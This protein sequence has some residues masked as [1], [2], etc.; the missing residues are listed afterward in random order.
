MKKSNARRKQET[1]MT[2][3]DRLSSWENE[4]STAFSHLSRPQLRGLVLWSAGIALT[5]AAGLCQM[6]ALLAEVLGQREP[7]VFQRLREWYL[8]GDQKSGKK[9]QEVEVSACF[10]P[11]LRWVVRLWAGAENRLPLVMDAT[12]LGKRST[13][14]AVSV[15]LKGGAIPVAWKVLC[16]EEEGSWR[17]H[18]EKLFADLQGAIPAEWLVIVLADRGLYARWL[19]DAM[20]ACGWH[21]F[22]RINLGVKASQADHN[23]FDWLSRWVPK[24]GTHWMGVIDCFAGKK[25]R[26]RATLLLHWEPGYESAWAIVTDLDPELAQVSWYRLRTWI[27]GGFKDF[28]RG[29]WGWQHSKMTHARC[30]ERLWLAMAL[31]QLW[32]LSVGAVVE[33]REQGRALLPVEERLPEKHVA[34]RKRHA[35]PLAQTPRRLSC[36]VRGRLHLLALTLLAHPLVVGRLLPEAWPQSIVSPQKHLPP[37]LRHGTKTP[38][39]KARRHRQKQRAYQ[40]SKALA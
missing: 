39:D 11:L 35:S 28:K 36:V 4:V 20:R 25:S 21:P 2:C 5:G 12:S 31:A 23:D 6:S 26:L 3:L 14:L 30:V 22:L 27:E 17:P 13:V 18:G 38:R 29:L 10:A 16:A 9:R 24:P 8:D 15:V 1:T 19:W 34:R 33:Q 7:T 40:R 32:C 37:A